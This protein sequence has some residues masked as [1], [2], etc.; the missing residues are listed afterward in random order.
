MN[1][2]KRMLRVRLVQTFVKVFTHHEIIYRIPMCAQNEN[3][4]FMRTYLSCYIG[5]GEKV[6][7]TKNNSKTRINKKSIYLFKMFFIISFISLFFA[8][9]YS[10]QLIYCWWSNPQP[11]EKLMLIIFRP[12]RFFK[13]PAN[14]NWNNLKEPKYFS[15]Q[16]F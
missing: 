15:L 3:C 7:L 1:K 8:I 10:Q 13:T 12:L 4:G 9:T 6:S 11:R 5:S 16:M 2:T 14:N